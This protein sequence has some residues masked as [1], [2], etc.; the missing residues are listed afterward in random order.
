MTLRRFIDQARDAGTAVFALA[1]DPGVAVSLYLVG[2]VLIVIVDSPRLLLMI[3]WSALGII[4]VH[5]LLARPRH[6]R[7][8]HAE[9]DE[10]MK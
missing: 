9:P 8:R 3:G 1:S 7:R 6:R 5:S 2:W 4:I 10:V